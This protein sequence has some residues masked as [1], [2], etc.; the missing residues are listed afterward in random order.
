MD[1][2]NSNILGARQMPSRLEARG[3]WQDT[4]VAAPGL[5]QIYLS[6]RGEIATKGIIGIIGKNG[7]AGNLEKLRKLS[8]RG[9]H[10][11]TPLTGEK[12][13]RFETAF[14]AATP[15]V[16]GNAKDRSP[17]QPWMDTMCRPN[18]R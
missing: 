6:A 1:I 10:V 16:R 11:E 13:A 7:A 18:A 3:R 9:F 8:R 2:Q 12:S 17:G 15:P 4:V 5:R 14:F